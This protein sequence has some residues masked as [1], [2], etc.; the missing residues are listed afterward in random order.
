LKWTCVVEIEC[1]GKLLILMGIEAAA[2]GCGA[3]AKACHF[4][5]VLVDQFRKRIKKRPD[6]AGR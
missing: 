4:G 2:R 5:L 3:V 1:I 6:F